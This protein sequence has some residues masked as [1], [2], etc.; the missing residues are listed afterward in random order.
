MTLRLYSGCINIAPG[1][2]Q[3]L[4]SG[5]IKIVQVN[6]ATYKLVMRRLIFDITE[7]VKVMQTPVIRVI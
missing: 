3:C 1:L 4:Y 7:A 6:Q 2:S 5:C